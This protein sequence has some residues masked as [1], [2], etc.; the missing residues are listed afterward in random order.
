MRAWVTVLGL[1]A[2]CTSSSL[3]AQRPPDFSIAYQRSQMTAP[4]V[5]D[6][7]RLDSAGWTFRA[8]MASKDITGPAEP[9]ELDSAYELVREARLDRM[10]SRSRNMGAVDGHSETLTL[11][12]S[13]ETKVLR[14]GTHDELSTGDPDSYRKAVDGLRT[15][16]AGALARLTSGVPAQ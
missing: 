2:S 5:G 9:E 7:W 16:A 15:L 13:G 14:T 3:P 12:I 10:A 8:T 4:V 1:Q 11:V 6:A